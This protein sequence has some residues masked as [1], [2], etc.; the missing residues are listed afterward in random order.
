MTQHPHV[1]GGARGPLRILL[2]TVGSRGDVQPMLGLAQTL[3]ARGHVPVVAAPANFETWV[4]TQGFE[5]A[6]LGTDV[7][8]FLSANAGVLTGNVFS[9]LGTITRY[10]AQEIPLWARQAAQAAQGADAVVWAGLAV[11]VPSVAEHLHLPAMGVNYSNCLIPSG[12]HPPP[13]ISRHGMP[14][15]INRLL[16]QMNRL[17]SQRMMGNPVNAARRAWGLPDVDFREHIFD[18]CHYALASDEVLFPR[19]PAWAPERFR[20]ANYIFFDDPAP[21]DAELEAWLADGEPPVFVG[22]GSMSGEGIDKAGKVIV[23]GVSATGRRCI[24]GAGWAGLGSHGLPKGWRV[25]RDAPHALLFP[26]MAAVVHH[27]GAG[28]MAQVL[29]AGV[30]QVILPLFMDQFHHA[31]RLHLASLVP[32][33]TPMERVSARSLADAINAA[34][35]L[36]PGPREAVAQRLR[37]SDGRGAIADQV[38]AMFA[39]PP[40]AES[41]AI[42]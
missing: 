32:R 33:P 21:L 18:G 42:H 22:F 12:M 16:W 38:E 26:R 2:A 9:A 31:H 20:Y 8:A 13:T 10:F 28:T 7:Q 39:T 37:A 11:V 40:A 27:G 23:D 17:M 6:P 24:V 15:W 30:P 3:A 35:A 4:R 36:P 25:V 5:F 1:P 34:L 19:D 14:G 41:R 29:R